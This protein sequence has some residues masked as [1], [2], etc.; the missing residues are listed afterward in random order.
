[1]NIVL[2][3]LECRVLGSLIEKELTTPEL[4]PLTLNSLILACN[5]K[6]NRNPVLDMSESH[7]MDALDSLRGK[8]LAWER[9]VAGARVLKYE[10]N[11]AGVAQFS[12][13]ECAL[14]CELLLRGPQTPGEL[15]SRA[16]RMSA[17]K[18]LIEVDSALALLASRTEGPFVVELPRQPGSREVRWSHL[19]SGIPGMPEIAELPPS[20]ARAVS[21]KRIP[22]ASLEERI[23]A[24][25][26]EVAGLKKEIEICK[27]PGLKPATPA[28]G[29]F[30]VLEKG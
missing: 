10:H 18:D 25:E 8:H 4:Y 7:C 23:T 28:S 29:P 9:R 13:A 26:I 20:P 6:S 16:S 1:M 15:R 14:L 19:F 27:D 12:M 11:L 24:L 5:Q 2:T 17:F 22:G 3:S 30:P 21:G